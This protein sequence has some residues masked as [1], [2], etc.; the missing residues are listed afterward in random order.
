M[1]GKI[2]LQDAPKGF[3]LDQDKVVPPSETVRRF[4]QRLE[5][6]NLD[7]LK[8]TIRI[9]SGRLG[10][11]VYFSTC[12]TDALETIGTKKQMGKGATPEQAEASAVMEL[13][14]RYS[15]FSFVKDASNFK[16]DTY[17]NLRESAMSFDQ[18]AKSVHDESDDLPVAREIFDR[19]ALK[20]TWGFNL[21]TGAECL[22]PFDWFYAINEFNGPSA[23]NCQEEAI[24]QGICEIV[25][26]HT[27]SLVSNGRLRV[28][29]IRAS[30]ASDPIVA[31]LIRK[32][33]DNG[34]RLYIS[35]F[36]L[37][38]GIPTVGIMAYDPATFPELSEIVW[39]AGTTPDPEKALS[40]A[41]TETAQLAG[42]FNSGA[43]YV[44]SGLPKFIRLEDADF[45]TR[46]EAEVDLSTLPNLADDNIR[47][48][49]ENCISALSRRN[50]EVF[51]ID[52][53]HARL[54]VPAFYT[55][56]PGARFRE[57]S[58][59]TSVA[60]FCAKHVYQ[61]LPPRDAL[62]ALSGI[63]AKLPDRY[64]VRFYQ[65]ASLLNA[66]EPQG[67]LTRFAKALQL[68]PP[69]ED[70]AS[71]YSYM[72]V[73]LRDLEQYDKALEVLKEGVEHDAERTDLFNLMGF[74]LFKLKKHAEAIEQFQKVI[75]LDPSSA[76]D[77]ANIGVN[78]RQM[79][80]TEKAIQYYRMALTLDPGIEFAREHLAELTGER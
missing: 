26:R 60:M 17:P 50:L 1:K 45:I 2:K 13:A 72:G 48:E 63:A 16:V 18:I 31:E 19:L 8:S 30:S 62:A 5:R 44:A 58:Q 46:P 75:K 25:E 40:R 36:T 4:K 34:I 76:I 68:T 67:A 79:G 56:V 70:R 12:G 43:N 9:D 57:R 54:K 66:G 32:Y 35:D 21:T 80:R 64:F 39:T 37:D 14:E 52:T 78:Y 28:P 53:K 69:R 15:F 11:P 41:L 77:Y 23:G 22:I 3:T 29:A 51:L 33:E 10:I 47:V 49:V 61:N 74:C 27:C 59:G 55:I 20:W 7:I 42:D 71:I 24:L 38:T 65:G 73:A 6:I